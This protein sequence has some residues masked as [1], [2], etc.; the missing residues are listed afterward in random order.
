MGKSLVIVESPAKAKTINKYLGKDYIVK[1]SV[2]HVRD[3]PTS[4]A[5]KTKGVATKSPAEV[6]KMSPEEKAA[7]RKQKDY[8][9]LVAR[10]GIDPEKGWEPHY[11]VLPGKEKVV[12]ELTK[13]AQD[14]DH[15]Y[16]ATDLDREG[17]AIAW[18]LEEIIGG[19]ASKYKRVVF[20]EITKNAI[21]QA[22]EAPGQLNT[23]MVYAQQARRFLD[24]VVGF[25]VSPLLWQK[26]ARGLSAGRVQSVA[27]RLLVEREREIKAFIPEEFWDIHADTKLAATDVRFAVTKYQG[28]AFKPVNEKEALKA[29]SEIENAS[30]SVVKVEEKPSKSKPS[31]PFITSTMQQAASTRLGYGVKKTMMLAQ[32]LYEAGF[33]TYMRTDSTNLSND[34]VEMCR[35]YIQGNFG[36]KYLPKTPIKYS[37][38]GN[39]Q[40]AHEAIRPS[41]VNVLSGHVEGVDADAKKLYELIWRQFVACQMTPA[42]YDLTNITLGANDYTLKARGRVLRFD[43]WTKVQP[44]VRKKSEEEQALPA[45]AV[46]DSVDLV[47][48][49]PKQHFTKP[50]ARYSEASLVK[51]LEKRGI[52][53]P[54]T[55]AA[56]ISTIQE[57]GYVRVENRRFF[58]EKMGEIVT[59][60]LVENFNDLMNFDFTAKMEGRLDDIAEGEREWTQVLDKFYA[61]FSNQLELAGQDEADGG[62]RQN[63][64]VETDI[65][66]TTCGRKMGIRTASTG[67]FLGCTGYS[68][69]PKERCTTTMNLISGD[70][71]IDADVEDAETES[72]RQKKRCPICE[73]AMDSYLIDETRKIHVCGNNPACGGYVVEQGTFKIKGYDGPV[74]ECD[75]C[76]ADMQLKS[77]RFGKYFGC[78][79]EDCKNTRKLLKNGEPAP[80]KEDPVPLPELECEKSD[81]HF[82]L[83]DGASG[84][85]LAAHTFPKSRETRAPKVAELKRFRDRISPKFYYL[86]DAPEKDGDGNLAVVRYSRKT[87]TQYVMTEVEGKATGWKATFVEGKWVE[88][89]KKR[90]K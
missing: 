22:F 48:L 30:L 27:V 44:A 14:A 38:K 78:T 9:N 53:R 42:E 63:V 24:R 36:D 62:M 25:M 3:L 82:V 29:V 58:A 15:I 81:A 46:G 34:A 56:I 73:T 88:E 75:K 89:E 67:V 39:A 87:K 50:P 59:D 32:R 7:Y 57:R 37:A 35:D 77:G 43:G 72:L 64:M 4:G 47:N 76:G 21:Q 65:D 45:V 5:G 61:D 18:H 49:D 60:R 69:P 19:D 71:A 20:N 23:D 40:E 31:A 41:D 12:Q 90:K 26:V 84:I 74:I 54:S 17:E 51:E 6:R 33:I 68:L 10:M 8:A 16:L 11:E 52:G 83:R 13:L 28:Q 1:S 55:Y 85:F 2:G 66:C 80:P 79:K 70:E 86:A